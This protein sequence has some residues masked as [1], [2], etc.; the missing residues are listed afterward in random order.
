MPDAVALPYK[1]PVTG[2]VGIVFAWKPVV[3]GTLAPFKG[4]PKPGTGYLS[5]Q[6]RLPQPVNATVRIH[7]R[8]TAGELGDGNLVAQVITAADGTW[9]VDNLNPALRYDVV[10]RKTGYN[11]EIT[12]GVQPLPM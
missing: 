12:A 1:S 6:V 7:Y 10:S 2:Q 5:G 11:D 8:P 3:A 9:R 4:D